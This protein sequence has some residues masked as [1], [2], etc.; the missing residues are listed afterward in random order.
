MRICSECKSSKTQVTKTG[1]TQWYNTKTNIL[2]NK[3]YNKQ[4]SKNNPEYFKQY[5]KDNH[6]HRRK[7]DDQWRIDNREKYLEQCKRVNR[8]KIRFKNTRP[9]TTKSPRTGICSKCKRSV[10]SGEIKVTNMHH[11]KYD[12]SDPLAHTIELC[13]RCHT[14]EHKLLRDTSKRE[15]FSL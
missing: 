5:R 4:Y 12:E 1:K 9:I 13:V 10:G 2:C 14:K 8:K 6:D 7:Y 15:M 3:C 11:T